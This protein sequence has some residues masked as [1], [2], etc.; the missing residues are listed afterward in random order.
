[1][2]VVGGVPVALV[3][4]GDASH[5][6]GFDHCTDEREIW[7]GLACH[8]AARSVACVGAVEAEPNASHHLAH[9]VLGKIGVGTTRT[10]GGT[11]EARFDTAQ[12]RV[13][14]EPCG[15]WM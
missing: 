11:I 5:R 15:L 10:A 1:M 14:I 8:D 13:A 9:V 12:E 3:G 2:L 6:T 4:T 7:S